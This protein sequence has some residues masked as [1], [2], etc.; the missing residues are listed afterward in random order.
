MAG[1]AQQRG[2]K[3]SAVCALPLKCV[4]EHC[5]VDLN[6]FKPFFRRHQVCPQH[7]KVGG[8]GRT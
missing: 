1:C 5:E 3:R 7:M 6:G 8:P 2:Q 4:A